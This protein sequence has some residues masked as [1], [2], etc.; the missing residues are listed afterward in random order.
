VVTSPRGAGARDGL[1]A[2]GERRLWP[3]SDRAGD[4]VPAG[5]RAATFAVGAVRPQAG[6]PELPAVGGPAAVEAPPQPEVPLG[7]Q[8]VRAA[9]L[10]VTDRLARLDVELEPP[11]LGA[12]RIT[13]DQGDGGLGLRIVA[14]RAATQT[15]LVQALPE[16]HARLA[17]QG[18]GAA[19][20]VVAPPPSP[21]RPGGRRE[22]W[23]PRHPAPHA[24]PPPRPRAA[25][26]AESIDFVV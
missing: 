10:V 1:A 22:G 25:E 17:A 5:D 7:E 9:R 16:I 18:M 26:P 3:A 23:R 19:T 14:E 12:I 21:E 6:A 24:D 11:E 15:L 20:L 2:R 13:A 4:A 8:V